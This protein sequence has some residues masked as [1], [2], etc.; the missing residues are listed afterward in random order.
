M[1]TLVY[2]PRMFSKKEFKRLVNFVPEN[3]DE[4][5]SE[6]WQYVSERLIAIASRV[7]RVYS[8]AT[9]LSNKDISEYETVIIRA[10]IN[11]GAKLEHVGNP[12]LIAEAEAW[13]KMMETTPTQM[14]AEMYSACL[15]EIRTHI[16]DMVN[17]SL[18][19]GEMGV[20]F[21]ASQFQI[22]FSENIRIIRMLPFNPQD[23]LN[24]YR[25]IQRSGN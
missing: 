18:H 21:I 11:R 25:A 23:Y 17:N 5:A 1:R 16:I 13:L 19:E 24:R 22:S 9:C 3:F 12:I 10:L 7:R 14:V 6:F 2:V 15:Q 8:D 20:L 4:T